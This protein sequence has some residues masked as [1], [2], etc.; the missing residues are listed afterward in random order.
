MMYKYVLLQFKIHLYNGNLQI[1]K[2]IYTT[3]KLDKFTTNFCDIHFNW[4]QLKLLVNQH[5]M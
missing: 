4:I 5:E 2:D 1:S 3:W